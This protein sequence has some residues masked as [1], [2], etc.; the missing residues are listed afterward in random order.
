MS[1]VPALHVMHKF[2]LP[3]QVSLFL[4]RPEAENHGDQV[5][6]VHLIPS[7]LSAVL[8]GGHH[9]GLDEQLPVPEPDVLDPG[10]SCPPGTYLMEKLK[11]TITKDNLLG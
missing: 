2:K 3:S 1:L 5:Q 9:G 7:Q 6:K 8:Q 10:M 4:S 11:L